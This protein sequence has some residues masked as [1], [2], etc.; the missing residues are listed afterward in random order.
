MRS[1]CGAP[2]ALAHVDD[3]ARIQA[4][5]ATQQTDYLDTLRAH[6]AWNGSKTRKTGHAWL[7]RRPS[8]WDHSPMGRRDVT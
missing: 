6:L 4:H 3:I 1:C 8:R 7:Q 2:P 5:D